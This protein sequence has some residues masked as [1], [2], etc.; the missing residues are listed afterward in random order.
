M[1]FYVPLKP[2]RSRRSNRYFRH[3]VKVKVINIIVNQ[4]KYFLKHQEK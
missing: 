3:R 4:T 1:T 2:I